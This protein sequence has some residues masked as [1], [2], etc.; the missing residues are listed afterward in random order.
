MVIWENQEK[1]ALKEK[2]QE[3]IKAVKA[4]AALA[5]AVL[6]HT[7]ETKEVKSEAKKA[8]TKAFDKKMKKMIYSIEALESDV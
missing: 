4:E 1:E 7:D 5:T 6:E 2:A 3:N 8:I